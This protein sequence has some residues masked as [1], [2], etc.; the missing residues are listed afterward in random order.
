MLLFSD[1]ALTQNGR[2][3]PDGIHTGRG[4]VAILLLDDDHRLLSRVNSGA[5]YDVSTIGDRDLM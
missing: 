3:F 1:P 5:P 4:I 2:Y